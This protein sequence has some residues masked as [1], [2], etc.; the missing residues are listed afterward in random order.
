M[1]LICQQLLLFVYLGIES[2]YIR[3]WLGRGDLVTSVRGRN[4]VLS[5]CRKHFFLFVSFLAQYLSFIHGE[6]LLPLGPYCEVLQQVS[7]F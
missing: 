7:P 1:P 3:L 4:T 5:I 6:P 2:L